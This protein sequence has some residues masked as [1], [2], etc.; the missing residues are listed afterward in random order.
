MLVL[1]RFQYVKGDMLEEGKLSSAEMPKPCLSPNDL[2][3]LLTHLWCND[4]YS[5]RGKCADRQRVA[6]NFA[7]LVYCFTS[8]RTGELYESLCRRQVRRL[9]EAED[10]LEVSAKAMTTC[11]KVQSYKSLTIS[12][13]NLQ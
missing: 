13:T 7:T 6:L 4:N 3:A 10:N 2:T 11:Y 9:E 1:M 5:Y 8:A 12:L